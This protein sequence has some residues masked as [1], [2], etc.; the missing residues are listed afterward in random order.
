MQRRTALLSLAALFAAPSAFAQNDDLRSRT[1]NPAADNTPV[2]LSGA[3][4][5]QAIARAN[6]SLN[7]LQRLQGRF[8]QTSP[9]HTISTGAFYLQR[10]GKVR[11][12]YDPPATLL[13]VSDGSVVSMRNSAM[14]TTDR[15]PL[16]STPLNMILKSQIDMARDARVTRVARWPE[17]TMISVTDP[18]GHVAG[19][20]TLFFYG[21]NYELRVWDVTD[22]TGSR[23]RVA[24]S[25][26]T[27]PGSLDPSLF[28]QEDVVSRGHGRN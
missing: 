3:D 23:T 24:L 17:G 13:I 19:R 5:D 16:R 2:D 18:Q 14:H 10:P 15:T 6:S 4:R 26:I 21:D 7:V 25:D 12:E 11:F 1:A 8:T 20:L 9:N 27:Q 22:V 28:R